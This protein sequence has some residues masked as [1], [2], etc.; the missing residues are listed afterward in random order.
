VPSQGHGQKSHDSGCR[1]AVLERLVNLL[2]GLEPP[3][4]TR[5]GIDGVDAAGKTTLADELSE[6]VLSIGRPTIRASIDGFHR[7]RAERY[8]RGPDSPEGYY[9]DSFDSAALRETLLDPLGPLG[10]RR[11]RTSVFDFRADAPVAAP[12]RQASAKAVLLF[13]G[14]FLLQPDLA[15]LW[16]LV[17]HVDVDPEVALERAVTRDAPSLGSADAGRDRYR[18]RYIPGQAIYHRETRPRQRADVVLD[19]SDPALPRLVFQADR[20]EGKDG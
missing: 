4:P 13:D 12:L 6:L 1:E 7:P 17:V 14:V 19:N 20:L 9:R 18:R 16:D 3:H 2:L 5:I 11:Y 8:L 10:D 15:G